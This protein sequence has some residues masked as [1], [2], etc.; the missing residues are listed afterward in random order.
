MDVR[1]QGRIRVSFVAFVTTSEIAAILYTAHNK[2][3]IN[4]NKIHSNCKKID[5]ATSMRRRVQIM[6]PQPKAVHS[7]Y[8][9]QHSPS[10]YRSA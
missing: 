5:I 8:S 4:E 7:A 2:L 1:G 9:L 3:P 10:S 6:F